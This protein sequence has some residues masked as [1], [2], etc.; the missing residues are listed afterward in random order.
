MR[1]SGG[2]DDESHRRLLETETGDGV[3][4]FVN[5]LS[6]GRKRV[7]DVVVVVVVVIVVVVV[8][9]FEVLLVVT[10]VMVIFIEY[11]RSSDVVF[12]MVEYGQTYRNNSLLIQ[13]HH[14]E[15]IDFSDQKKN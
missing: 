3:G 14:S 9:V 8:V 15:N 1:T 5:H 4:I 10:F 12:V 6:T 13:W 2:E 11:V 7:V